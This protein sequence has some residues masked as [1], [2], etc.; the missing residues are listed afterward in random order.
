MKHD[1]IESCIGWTMIYLFSTMYTECML[2]Q[3]TVPT[4]VLQ[5]RM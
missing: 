5:G 1:M 4:S 2:K 3:I